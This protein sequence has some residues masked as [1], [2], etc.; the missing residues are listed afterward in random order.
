VRV[1]VT[2]EVLAEGRGTAI[3]EDS[4]TKITFEKLEEYL[5][6]GGHLGVAFDNSGNLIDVGRERRLFTKRQRIGLAV[7]DGGCRYPGCD[8]PPSWTEAHHILQWARDHG[9][10]DITNGILLCRYHHM[11]IH[12][13]GAEIIRD[14]PAFWLRLPKSMDPT[15]AL[16]EMP[17]KNPIVAAMSR[18]S[19][20]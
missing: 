11:L 15:Q 8:K 18:S 6:E 2:D 10:T 14:G 5:C 13:L 20:G 9:R 17:S 1:I 19:V 3:L 16:V 7:R 4:L 12:E